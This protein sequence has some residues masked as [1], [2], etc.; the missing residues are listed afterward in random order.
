MS[1]KDFVAIAQTLLAHKRNAET[2]P[3]EQRE[4]EMARV[5]LIAEDFSRMFCVYPRFNPQTFLTACGY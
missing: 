5:R 4:H 1:K 2:L 3:G